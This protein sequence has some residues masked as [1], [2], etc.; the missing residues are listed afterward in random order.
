MSFE[1]ASRLKGKARERAISA[2]FEKYVS[3]G[4]RSLIAS[5]RPAGDR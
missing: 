1:A 5:A 4:H 2:H 3:S